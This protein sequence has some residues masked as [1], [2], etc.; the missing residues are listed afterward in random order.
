[1]Y[2]CEGVEADFS[3]CLILELHMLYAQIPY[4][5]LQG[6]SKAK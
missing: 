1:M 4:D 5:L 6:A 3:V 2:L